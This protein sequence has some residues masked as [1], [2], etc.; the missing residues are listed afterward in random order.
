MENRVKMNIVFGCSKEYARYVAVMLLSLFENNKSFISLYA[1]CEGEIGEWKNKIEYLVEK[2]ENSIQ[3]IKLPINDREKEI[4]NFWPSCI[5]IDRYLAINMLPE[6]VER[7][8]M[9][10]IDILVRGDLSELYNS[11]FE[12]KYMIM[13]KDQ[14]IVSFSGSDEK[15]VEAL[16]SY[17]IGE[18]DEKFGNSGVVLV[19]R[20]IRKVFD[21]HAMVDIIIENQYPYVEQDFFNVHMGK[22]IKLIE[23]YEYNYLA[24]L[25]DYENAIDKVKILHYALIKPWDVYRGTPPWMDLWFK[26]AQR[27]PECCDVVRE[28]EN[29][30][31]DYR[32]I[33]WQ[34]CK[35]YQIF[36]DRWM[37][38]RDKEYN[39]FEKHGY[40]LVALYGA[41]RMCEHLLS[42]LKKNKIICKGIYDKN[43]RLKSKG[44]IELSHDLDDFLEM[45]DG[46]DVIIVTAISAYE[47]IE[48]E[49]KEKTTI[50][51]ISLED[52]IKGGII[53]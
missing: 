42:D 4:K 6:D 19:N 33:S 23:P 8:L 46:V 26:Y 50:K 14:L 13:C 48:S 43:K 9:L 22:Y 34:N 21:Y 10:D 53:E 47:E 20:E 17:K 12:N 37:E 52:L 32:Y 3:F 7:F 39:V 5:N 35:K 31:N 1:M 38:I 18:L 30:M 45:I 40:S 28:Y 11:D 25:G 36:L 44:G 24:G 27:V 51:T 41:G 16:R 49:L 29:Y 2:Y 15:W